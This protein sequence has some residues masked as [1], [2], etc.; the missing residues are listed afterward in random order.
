MH[1]ITK[2]TRRVLLYFIALVLAAGYPISAMADTQE[3][4]TPP[5]DTSEQVPVEPAPTPPQPTYTYNQSTGFWD[6]EEWQ[7]NPTSGR[8]ETPPQPV[9]IEPTEAAKNDESKSVDTTVTLDNDIT[10]DAVSG[11]STINK[12]TTGGSATTGD[13]AAIATLVNMVNS[14]VGVGDNQ[15]IASFTQDI[16]GDVK[17]DIIL[18]PM[19]LKAML[20]AEA[21]NDAAT[22]IDVKNDFKID[23]TIGLTAKSGDANVTNNTAAG[24][25]TTGSATAVA[26]VVNILNSMIAT[27]QSFIGTINI[28]GNLEGDILIA[29]DFIP[30]MLASNTDDDSSKTKVSTKDSTDIINNITAVAESGAAAVLNNTSAGNAETGKA[31]TGV[32]IFNLTGHEIIAKNS[33]LVFVNVLGKWVGV[34]VDAPAGA[35]SALIGNEVTKNET[36]SPDLKVNAESKHGI[37]NTISVDAQSG[38]AVVSGNTM[39]GGAK[40]GQ[41]VA[42]A[43]IANLSGSQFGISDWFGVLF[44][45]VFQNWHGSFG[46]DTF[47][48]NKEEPAK[49]APT[50]PIQFVPA[51]ETRNSS[52]VRASSSSFTN[53][54]AQSSHA[55]RN[56]QPLQGTSDDTPATLGKSTTNDNSLDSGF[57][58]RLFIV[59]G[60]IL[61]VGA[62]LLGL[63][64]LL[65]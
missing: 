11:D 42:L 22:N 1:I 43:N 28:Y 29:P 63:K 64:R 52:S 46:I 45:N 39:A 12:N 50:G 44:I 60:S 5:A 38:D 62:S 24:D 14:S 19:L 31:D 20:E 65:S 2:M 27:Q 4:T 40:T 47:Y 6:S 23:N 48:G 58:Y 33:L 25:A 13:A 59:G 15:K 26:N 18:Y 16:L 57:D 49:P 55:I 56:T 34:I 54:N 51:A 9:V 41:A 21:G 36:Y 35:T 8:Y 30:Q 53:I 10:S 37:T 32:V 7:Y 3:P 61:I 17:G